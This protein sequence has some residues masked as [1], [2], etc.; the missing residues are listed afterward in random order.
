MPP[1]RKERIAKGLCPNCG[2]VNDRAPKYLCSNCLG[3]ENER[4]RIWAK[5]RI[6]AGYCPYCARPIDT[7]GPYCSVCKAKRIERNRLWRVYKRQAKT[8]E[9]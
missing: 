4:K 8:E 5:E 7:K 9:Q 2:E 6:K 3:R 1:N